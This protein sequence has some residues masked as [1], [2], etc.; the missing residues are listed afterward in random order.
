MNL[1]DAL[2]FVACMGCRQGWAWLYWLPEVK[3]ECFFYLRQPIISRQ[4]ERTAQF[5]PGA[6]PLGGRCGAVQT[7]WTACATDTSSVPST[8][9]SGQLVLSAIEPLPVFV[10]WD[11]YLR[12][13]EPPVRYSCIKELAIQGSPVAFFLT[14]QGC[15]RSLHPLSSLF[16]LDISRLRQ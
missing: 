3:L 12:N 2:S 11:T 6:V 5:W 16:L 14:G 4:S 1:S 10:A 7:L 9:T 15:S 8:A 13:T